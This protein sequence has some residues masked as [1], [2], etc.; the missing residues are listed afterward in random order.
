MHLFEE[1]LKAAKSITTETNKVLKE[2][3][4]YISAVFTESRATVR[5]Q[6]SKDR[7]QK[8]NVEVFLAMVDKF[9][10]SLSSRFSQLNIYKRK[11]GLILRLPVLNQQLLEVERKVIQTEQLSSALGNVVDKTDL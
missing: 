11:F 6:S 8:Y 5:Q 3:V 4:M 7:K 10:A 1:E 2:D 9:T